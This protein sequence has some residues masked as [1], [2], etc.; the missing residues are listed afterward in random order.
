MVKIEI[1]GGHTTCKD[2]SPKWLSAGARL[3]ASCRLAAA[4]LTPQLHPLGGEKL[5]ALIP[6][7]K[8]KRQL[9][10]TGPSVLLLQ[11]GDWWLI[12]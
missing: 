6:G 7:G 12:L 2:T 4:G 3:F 1:A 11:R 8:F 10:G 9:A 5:C